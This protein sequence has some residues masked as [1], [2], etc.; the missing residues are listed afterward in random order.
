MDSHRY[1]TNIKTIN[2][3]VCEECGAK[4]RP[5][6]RFCSAC[7]TIVRNTPKP[8]ETPQVQEAKPVY[9]EVEVYYYERP[10]KKN[11]K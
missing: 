4:L 2:T 8:V 10:T 7:G 1:R 6:A 5:G 9:K 3:G 11:K